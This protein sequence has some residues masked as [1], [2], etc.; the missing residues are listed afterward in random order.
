M[1]WIN[2]F[3]K[4]KYQEVDGEEFTPFEILE[5]AKEEKV[6]VTAKMKEDSV[7]L[8]LEEKE[9]SHC[10]I[11]SWAWFLD[12]TEGSILLNFLISNGVFVNFSIR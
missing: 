5:L 2:K 9:N 6:I 3:L 1:K 7:V 8:V 12:E 10:L 11:E 4:E